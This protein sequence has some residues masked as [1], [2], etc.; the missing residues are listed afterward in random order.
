MS[1]QVGLDIG[2]AATTVSIAR[3]ATTTHPRKHAGVAAEVA[4]VLD[5]LTARY[6]E[7]PSRVAMTHR[8]GWDHHVLEDL[9]G[10]LIRH[11]RPDILFVPEPHAAVKAYDEVAR[12]PECS[13]VVV[14]DFGASRCD[15]TVLC[16]QGVFMV[17]GRPETVDIGGRDIDEFVAE[18]VAA[19]TGCLTAEL[20]RSCAEAKELLGSY[21]EVRVPVVVP[22]APLAEVRLSRL[23]FEAIIRPAVGLVV[24]AVERV[25]HRPD[26][27][28][29]VG[30]SARI[31]LVAREIAERL[32]IPA[33]KA[34]DG[35]TARGAAHEAM[36]LE[37]EPVEVPAVWVPE[38]REEERA[39]KRVGVTP[40]VAVGLMAVAGAFVAHEVMEPE[41]PRVVVES[42]QLPPPGTAALPVLQP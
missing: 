21:P 26:L 16:K 36:Q 22:D 38:R 11:G 8:L 19:R 7:P 30:G 39:K 37:P 5:E 15:V 2:S 20:K 29:L 17:A 28:L 24:D 40:F 42:V 23:E 31:P 27:I 35:A 12:L 32:G 3:G 4:E 13:T 10:E 9:R 18:H 1:Y 41:A 25:R 14:C 34:P 6:G 33:I